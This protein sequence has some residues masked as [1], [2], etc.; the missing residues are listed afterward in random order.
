[1]YISMRALTATLVVCASAAIVFQMATGAAGLQAS[2]LA[3]LDATTPITF[4]IDEGTTASGYRP[5]DRQLAT[6]ALEAWQ[7]TAGGRLRFTPAGEADAIVRVHWVSQT[8]GQY[9]EMQPV[10]VRGRRG[11]AVYIQPDTGALGAAI[12]GA[13]RRDPLLRDAVVYLTCVHELGHALGLSHTSEFADIMYFFG[14][15]GDIPE[16]FARYRRQLA[17]RDDIPRFAGVSDADATRVRAMY[18]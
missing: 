12:A 13:T 2:G 14:Y 9:G 15:G 3:P 16:F 7:R 5:G 1:M 10:F 11:A 17:A 8:Q 18:R 6:W 4:F